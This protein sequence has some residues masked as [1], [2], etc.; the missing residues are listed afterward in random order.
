MYL[1]LERVAGPREPAFLETPLTEEDRECIDALIGTACDLL[2]DAGA[3]HFRVEGFG[4]GSWPVSVRTD[5]SVVAQQLADL[6]AWLRSDTE[7]GFDLE[8]WEQGW[9]RLLHFRRCDDRVVAH[10]RS[11]GRWQ[12]EPAE[13]TLPLNELRDMLSEFAAAF[14]REAEEVSPE[15]AA[16][17]TFRRW[18]AHVLPLK[19]VSW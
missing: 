8:F 10:C 9:D 14:C 13:E 11:W 12:P 18:A 19:G 7:A 15:I 5:L 2:H 1:G 16:T 3:L 6:L 17:R 4:A